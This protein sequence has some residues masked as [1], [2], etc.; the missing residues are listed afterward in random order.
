M[1]E[2]MN[3]VILSVAH[4]A[5]GCKDWMEVKQKW[6]SKVCLYGY[7]DPANILYLGTPDR[8]RQECQKEIE[9]LGEGGGFILGPGCEFPPNASLLSAVAMMD[10][11]K[12]YGQYQNTGS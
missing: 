6:G 2:T 9:E 5:H 8:V 12:I 10:G 11:A 4:E 3:P 1:I 7:M